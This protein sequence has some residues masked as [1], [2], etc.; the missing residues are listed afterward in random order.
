MYGYSSDLIQKPIK[1][2]T[3]TCRII[4]L[5]MNCN[6]TGSLRFIR[7]K[8]GASKIFASSEDNE[9]RN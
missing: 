3:V 9:R 5:R 1:I 7:A 8:A 6:R 4:F 2:R